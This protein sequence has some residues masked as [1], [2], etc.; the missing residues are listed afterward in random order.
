[1]PHPEL[2]LTAHPASPSAADAV[3]L[4]VRKTPEGP[5][6]LVDDAPLGDLDLAALGVTGAVDEVVRVPSPNGAAPYV[7]SGVGGGE[8]DPDALRAAAGAAIRRLGGRAHVALDLPV[9]DEAG[10]IAALEGAGTAAYAFRAYKS[11]EA[12]AASTPPSHI[13]LH[14]PAT[15][16][17]DVDHDGARLVAR[18][19]ATVAALHDVRDLVST[20]ANDLFPQSF[21][22]RA[23]A[24]RGQLPV[25]IEVLD[26]AALAAGGFGGILG[27]GSGSA[28]PPRLVVLRYTPDDA[29]AHVA[30]VGKGITFDS[31]GLSLKPPS[32]MPTMKYDMTGAA[33]ALVTTLAAARLG[34]P[35]RVTA[36]LCLAE[37]MP[38]GSAM[39]PGDVLRI[40]GGG[41]VEVTNTDAEGRLVLADGI[42]AAGEEHPD[43]IVDVATLTGAARTAL[44][45]RVIPVMGDPTVARELIDAGA[46]AGET[47]WEMPMPGELRSL[48]D[49]D[50]ADL[51]NAKLGSTVAPM[52]LAAVF[53][54][55]FVGRTGEGPEAPRIPWGHLDIAGTG[56][57]AGSPHGEVGKGPTGVAVRTLLAFL[58]SRAR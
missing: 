55:H 31:G 37:N 53:L 42:V 3:V 24:L 45:E 40:R 50:V 14:V 32:S 18:A 57:N 54:Q 48:L 6:L 49:S 7:L 46:R 11:E 52:M 23:E 28:R 47:L 20:P 9:R 13:T 35:V 12:G 2:A 38:S 56:Y 8:P 58:E 33:T 25:E 29:R 22:E 16:G 5:R 36:W 34:L 1:M 10:A 41:T 39:R 21:A 27:V 43:A 51:A 19:S 30:L 15:A 4:A 44:G 26:E 17:L